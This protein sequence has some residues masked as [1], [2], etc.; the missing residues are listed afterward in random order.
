MRILSK[1]KDYYD[2]SCTWINNELV[3]DRKVITMDKHEK[4]KK[5]IEYPRVNNQN[6][7]AR[8]WNF[9]YVIIANKVYPFVETGVPIYKNYYYKVEESE[10]FWEFNETLKNLWL[11]SENRYYTNSLK[12]FFQQKKEL[13]IEYPIGFTMQRCNFLVYKETDKVCNHDF[14]KFKFNINLKRLKC[15]LSAQF[16]TQEIEM[17]LN[18][19][20]NPEKNID[21]TD[22]ELLLSKG[23]DDKT[24]FRN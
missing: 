7:N 13:E 1:H 23:F 9:G 11:T 5:I 3:Y 2:F 15:P 21:M 16:V 6:S 10:F 24:S 17:F 8:Q 20:Y 22:K 19:Q 4:F 18:K 14:L 12:N